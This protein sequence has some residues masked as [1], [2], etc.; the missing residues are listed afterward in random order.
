MVSPHVLDNNGNARITTHDDDSEYYLSSAR[1]SS[2]GNRRGSS[3]IRNPLLLSCDCSNTRHRQ[4][5]KRVVEFD[6]NVQVVGT[7]DIFCQDLWW[8]R[9]DIK[10]FRARAAMSAISCCQ[11]QQYPDPNAFML[12]LNT[13]EQE[14]QRKNTVR[15]AWKVVSK[16]C[17]E[18]RKKKKQQQH[19]HQNQDS[20]YLSI[21]YWECTR[22]SQ[23]EATQRGTNLAQELEQEEQQCQ[24]RQQFHREDQHYKQQQNHRQT[25]NG[26]N[27]E[28]CNNSEMNDNKTGASGV[29]GGSNHTSATPTFSPYSTQRKRSI[30]VQRWTA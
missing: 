18:F 26:S 19:P 27:N 16:Y 29:G 17:K 4:Q 24:R 25:S 7:K 15:K 28:R 22:Q 12:G 20:E 30:R 23:W 21:V 14:M 13:E 3:L 9:Q 6:N 11:R 10:E 1:I 5:Q 8:T 2:D